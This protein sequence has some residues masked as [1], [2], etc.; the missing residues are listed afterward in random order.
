MYVNI[1][2]HICIYNV[3]KTICTYIHILCVCMH[4]MYIKLLF[5]LGKMIQL[6]F[7]NSLMAKFSDTLHS[8]T[9]K[10]PIIPYNP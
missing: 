4:N 3:C 1:C 2:K 7:I 6:Q 9:E 5:Q 10:Q 8:G